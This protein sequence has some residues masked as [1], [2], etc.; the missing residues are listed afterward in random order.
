MNVKFSTLD[1]GF[2]Q[3]EIPVE[4]LDQREC[5]ENLWKVEFNVRE[6]TR[7]WSKKETKKNQG[8]PDYEFDMGKEVV[9]VSLSWEKN[10]KAVIN[11]MRIHLEAYPETVGGFFVDFIDWW[12]EWYVVVPC[13]SREEWE[14]IGGVNYQ[15]LPYTFEFDSEKFIEMTESVKCEMFKILKWNKINVD[16]GRNVGSI[17]NDSINDG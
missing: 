13:K 16:N 17:E 2:E 8:V 9:I 11:W 14:V 5:K 7:Y 15:I 4:M 1:G 3:R 10:Y 6:V 12:R